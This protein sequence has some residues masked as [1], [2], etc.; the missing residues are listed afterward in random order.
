MMETSSSPELLKEEGGGV[1]N[2]QMNEG[3]LG[4][5]DDS[6]SPFG[7]ENMDDRKDEED[8]QDKEGGDNDDA[9]DDDDDNEEVY[10]E[11]IQQLWRSLKE[12]LSEQITEGELAKIKNLCEIS[13]KGIH[14]NSIRTV[15][16][17]LEELE[18]CYIVRLANTDTLTEFLEDVGR[19]DLV[20]QLLQYNEILN[21]ELHY[22]SPKF[23][24]AQ[25]DIECAFPIKTEL[26]Y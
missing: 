7:H 16:G 11:K 24:V 6:N 17:L 14:L 4:V 3:E 1:K 15:L 5:D 20:L 13:H 12:K 26:H 22:N 8:G 2:G 18:N 9:D 10:S 19:T 21:I 23:G 25:H